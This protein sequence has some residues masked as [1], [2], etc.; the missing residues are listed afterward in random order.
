MKK[1]RRWI[2][3]LVLSIFL[4]GVT[5]IPGVA[6]EEAAAGAEAAAEAA[7]AVTAEPAV[8]ELTLEQATQLALENNTS[9]QLAEVQRKLKSIALTKARQEQR[10]Y[11]DTGN[12]SYST[13]IGFMAREVTPKTAALEEEWAEKVKASAINGIMVG[14]EGSYYNLLK[15]QENVGISSRS[16]ERAE[17]QMRQANARLQAGTASKI[18]VMQ[19]EAAVA[20]AEVALLAAENALGQSRRTLNQMLG[21]D[22]ATET[23][24][25]DA[26][27]FEPQEYV[28]DELLAKA[29]VEDTT[30]D[31]MY[32]AWSTGT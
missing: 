10:A 14:V 17:E 8:L 18:E 4:L 3:M 9:I 24:A 21:Q 23:K 16:L 13:Y 27:A 28:L 30:Y 32:L 2:S 11:E 26:I 7:Q 12:L 19:A 29:L 25:I 5:A 31:D 15:A 22:I 1:Q 6:E 20:G